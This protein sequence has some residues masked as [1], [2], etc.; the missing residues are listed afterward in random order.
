MD[1]HHLRAQYRSRLDEMEALLLAAE[2][3]G[4]DL[5]E[6]EQ[7]QYDAWDAELQSL[8]SRIERL[9]ELRAARDA[10]PEPAQ[11]DTRNAPR[12]EVRDYDE[13]D[14]RSLAEFVQAIVLRPGDQRLRGL[15]VEHREEPAYDGLEM[16]TPT[17][18][19]Y[20]VP[21]QFLDEI[22]QFSLP[23][24]VMRPRATVIPA[25]G[26]AP[27]AKVHIPTLDQSGELGVY[28][29]VQVSWIDEGGYKPAT[30][31]TFDQ[32]ELEP[33]EVAA[34]TEVTDKMLRNSAVIETIIRQLL[35]A[36][37]AAA[38]D[39]AFISGDGSGKPTGFIGH[40]SNVRVARKIAGDVT[41]DDVVEMESRMVDGA[42]PI[43]LVTKRAVPRLR[44]M[45][46]TEGHLIWQ[47]SARDGLPNTL[48]GYPVVVT[49]RAPALGSLGDVSFIDPRYYL[50]KD[51]TGIIVAASPHVQFLNNRTV[52]KAFKLVDGR[53]WPESPLLEENGEQASPFVVLDV[54]S[55]GDGDGTPPG[56]GDGA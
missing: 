5:T 13:R 3:E 41:Y 8:R 30:R 2:S 38:E 32:I 20:L 50:I 35:T 21:P 53:P 19:G 48:L 39:V 45:E 17:A 47:N 46:D 33:H 12:I 43:W 31:P 56:D 54:P 34:H 29:G 25:D 36:G 24:A 42:N 1:I 16:Q 49:N 37:L 11:P 6:E 14:F 7:R 18:G 44:H 15:F 26:S 55:E 4:R 9:Q 40:S 28:S 27:D 52:I 51:G 22:L 10:A 23:S